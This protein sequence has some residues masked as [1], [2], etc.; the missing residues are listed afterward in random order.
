MTFLVVRLELLLVTRYRHVF[1]PFF[2]AK[3]KL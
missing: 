2:Q 3:E 1:A